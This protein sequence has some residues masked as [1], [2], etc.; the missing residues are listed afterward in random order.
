MNDFKECTWNY[1]Y[2]DLKEAIP[3]NA[4][5]ERGKEIDLRGYIDSDHAEDNKKRRPRSGFF[6]FLNTSLIKYFSKKQATIE[7]SIFGA[8]FVSMKIVTETL[9]G[10]RYKLRIMGVPIYGPSFIYGVN[11]LVINN[12][13][14]PEFTLKKKSNSIFYHAVCESIAMGDSLT[15]NVGTNKNCADLATNVLYVGK[16]RFHVSNLL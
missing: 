7:T 8:E 6:I 9:R 4:P 16:C 14:R 15:G 1:F 10:I 12:N 11:M 3:T 2:G 5:E 13:Q